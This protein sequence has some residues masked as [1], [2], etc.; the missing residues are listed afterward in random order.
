M[1]IKQWHPQE[2][3]ANEFFFILGKAFFKTSFVFTLNYCQRRK[4]TFASFQN[5]S[6]P[7]L[8]HDILGWRHNIDQNE[9]E[10]SEN[11]Y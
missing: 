4:I 10:K 11:Q 8:G 9:E 6:Q 1:F 3:S 5:K 2:S 7:D